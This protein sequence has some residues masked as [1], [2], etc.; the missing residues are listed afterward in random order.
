MDQQQRGDK[1]EDT[2]DLSEQNDNYDIIHYS[3]DANQNDASVCCDG[4]T[5]NDYV[6]VAISCSPSSNISDS[7]NGSMYIYITAIVNS[8]SSTDGSIG[9]SSSSNNINRMKMRDATE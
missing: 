9:G 3:N 4:A 7:S 2:D 1:I 8:I 5:D 6:V